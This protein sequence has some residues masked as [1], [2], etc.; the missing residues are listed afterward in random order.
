[1]SVLAPPEPPPEVARPFDQG[2]EPSSTRVSA[3]RTYTRVSQAGQL[4]LAL[5][6]VTVATAISL[7]GGRPP[8]EPSVGE[9]VTFSLLLAVV[10]A[11][12]DPVVEGRR[13]RRRLAAA[14]PLPDG[15]REVGGRPLRAL[16][17]P[18][19]LLTGA[20][21]GGAFGVA[22]LVLGDDTSQDLV[23]VAA[24]MGAGRIAGLEIL[25]RALVERTDPQR[26]FFVP[27]DDDEEWQATL[28][29]RAKRG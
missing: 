21:L 5:A 24:G 28:Y 27:M 13:L 7:A 11:T 17:G 3:Y 15:A 20:M 26:V 8:W 18:P 29:W 6:A 14:E 2:S 1:M 23:S 25:L 16:L 19:V 9:L 12:V 22:A 10:F 4:G